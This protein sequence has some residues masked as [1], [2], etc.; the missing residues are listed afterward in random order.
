MNNIKKTY[1]GVKVFT[2][3]KNENDK[4]REWLLYHGYLFGYRNLYVIDNCSTDGTVRILK[5]FEK[6]GITVVYNIKDYPQKGVHTSNLMLT[7]KNVE[8]KFFTLIPINGD[9]FIALKKSENIYSSDRN[10]IMNYFQNLSKDGQKYSFDRYLTGIAGNEDKT[11]KVSE[12]HKFEFQKIKHPM[13]KKFYLSTTFQHTD[14]KNQFGRIS[15]GNESTVQTD[16]VLF[17]YPDTGFKN[18]IERAK[19]E[20]NGWGYSLDNKNN[21]MDLSHQSVRG[22]QKIKRYLQFLDGKIN[23]Q[24]YNKYIKEDITSD[25]I[26]KKILKLSESF[27]NNSNWKIK[28]FTFVK[29]EEDK[30]RE[31]LLYHGYLF[32]FN[33]IYVIDNCSSDKTPLILKEFEK[34]GIQVTYNVEDYSRKGVHLS[35][36]MTKLKGIREQFFVPLDC[37]EFIILQETAPDHIKIIADK[38]HILSYFD[39]LPKDG[40]KYEFKSVYNSHTDELSHKNPIREITKFSNSHIKKKFYL[41]TTFMNT[42]HGNHNGK[43]SFKDNESIHTD[44][45]L[46]HFSNVGFQRF[47]DRAYL[48][49]RGFGYKVDTLSEEQLEDLVKRKAVGSHKL[50][51][52][53]DYKKGKL[54]FKNFSPH[55]KKFIQTRVVQNFL[56]HNNSQ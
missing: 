53:L 1:G 30:I 23:V 4:I 26:S 8:D 10:E 38:K 40:R 47:I 43:V 9:E 18:Y 41:S 42:D 2:F 13:M 51:R 31:W 39:L 22:V 44:L 32:G 54:T 28:I 3:I 29:N 36:L 16:L 17:H 50:K 27:N 55:P 12:I 7:Q 6:R 25:E 35:R 24:N 46:L 15:P 45:C 20:I 34:K 11:Y 33:N 48:D 52:I 19:L 49:I 37:D 5:E 56:S 14:H 21:L